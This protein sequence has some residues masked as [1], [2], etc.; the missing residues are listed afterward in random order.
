MQQTQRISRPSKFA[1]LLADSGERTLKMVRIAEAELF[2]AL[3]VWRRV[4]DKTS[5]AFK[6]FKVVGAEVEKVDANL[7]H[8]D[9]QPTISRT[10]M[11]IVAGCHGRSKTY[12]RR[13]FDRLKLI[14]DGELPEDEIERTLAKFRVYPHVG[15]AQGDILKVWPRA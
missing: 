6:G 14:K 3:G 1:P 13:E 10:E 15:A 8:I 5:G 2:E 7:R 11:E 12:G 4:Y 9:T